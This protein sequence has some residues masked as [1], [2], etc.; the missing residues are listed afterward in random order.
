[1]KYYLLMIYE[2]VDDEMLSLDIVLNVD[3]VAVEYFD[4]DDGDDDA[5]LLALMNVFEVLCCC[6]IDL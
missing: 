4:D 3:V 2:V 1:M 6:K 5:G